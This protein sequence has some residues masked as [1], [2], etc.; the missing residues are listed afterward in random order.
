MQQ[1][2]YFGLLI[3][4]ALYVAGCFV[5]GIVFG[6][7]LAWKLAMTTAAIAYLSYTAQQIALADRMSY[8][9]GRVVHGIA[10]VLTLA[11]VGTGAIAGLG[12]LFR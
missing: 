5:A 1:A 9:A 4:S 3:N 2:I 12:L 7:P 10:I 8:E 6:V 11:S